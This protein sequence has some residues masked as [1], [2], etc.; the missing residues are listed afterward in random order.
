MGKPKCV[1]CF[2]FDEVRADHLSVYGYERRQRYIEELAKDGVVFEKAISPGSYTGAVTP[3]VWTG[4]YGSKSGV[5]DPYMYVTAPLLQEILQKAGWKT[6]GC[7]SQSVAGSGIGMDNGFDTFIEPTD[8][9]APDTWGDGVE[10]WEDLGV[11]VDER[12]HAKP[13]GKDYREDNKKFIQAN[14]AGNFYLYNQL[15]ETHT[16]SEKFMVESGRLEEGVMAENAYYDAKIKWGDENVIGGVI[17]E[18][19]AAGLYD[20]ALIIIISDHGTTLRAKNWPMGDYIYEPL[21]VGDLT[22]THSSLYDVDVHVPLIIKYPDMPAASKGKTIKGQVRTV[23]VP[24]TVLD[25]LGVPKEEW[26]EMDGESLVPCIEN[27][28]GHGHRTYLETVWAAYGM[29]ARQALREDNFKYIRYTSRMY[30]EFFDLTKDPAEQNNLIEAM[31]AHAPRWL[32]ELREECNDHYR[33][34]PRGIERR[35]MPKE[36]QE[37]LKARLKALGYITE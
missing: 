27:L 36:E 33:S 3:A 13:V 19:K 6:Q 9:N 12:F 1:Y 11:H 20:D 28:K 21:D 32:Q 16:G 34:E 26:P 2:Q 15:Y 17:E 24:A 8:P 18:L 4:C 7:M 35:E 29:G 14:K 37:A 23:D 22:N 31:K 5:R 25:I 10:H 30:E